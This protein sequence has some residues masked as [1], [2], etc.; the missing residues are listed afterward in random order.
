MAYHR[1]AI[2]VSIYVVNI[3]RIACSGEAAMAY[4]V[5]SVPVATL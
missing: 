5:A 1:V 3:E 4:Y 2:D